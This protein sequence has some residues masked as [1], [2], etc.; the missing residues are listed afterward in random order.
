MR[1]Q[2][3]LA[4]VLAG[5][6][7]A[8]L[9]ACTAAPKQGPDV[10]VSTPAVGRPAPPDSVQAALSR[11]AF[12]PYAA[13]GQSNND[14][15]APN[16]STN[17]LAAACMSV[18]GY[19]GSSDVMIGVRIGPAELAFSQPWGTWGYLGLADAE[20]YGF[21]M[22]PGSALANLGI[23]V[24][25]PGSNPP[26]IPAAE[27]TAG[28]KC[29]TI[30]Q[31]FTN[32]VDD[33]PLAG[34]QAISSGIYNDLRNDGSISNAKKAWAAC[35]T[36]N[37]YHVTD[38]QSAAF[39]EIATAHGET[40]GHGVKQIIVGGTSVNP[41]ENEAQIAMAVT[42]ANCTQSADLAGI[43]F[44][45]EASYEQQIVSANQQALASAV[46]QFRAD[47]QREVA[48]LPKLL[49][50]TKAEPFP[51]PGRVIRGQSKGGA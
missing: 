24:S 22:P 27:Q 15:L 34:I 46:Q 40:P 38:P 16:E 48:E 36:K 29:S 33:G 9:A 45:V 19:P 10:T 37:G 47:Y 18:A 32:A 11:M 28:E 12:T 8:G 26:S 51:T 41:A 4:V 2:S 13:L 6:C 21:L 42:D 44:A 49:S 5:I 17:A 50:T 39:N 35:M 7:C 25:T 23:G 30:V 1:I 43:Y 20:Q 14:G 3:G 31:D